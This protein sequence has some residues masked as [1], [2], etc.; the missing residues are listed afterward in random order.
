MAIVGCA[1]KRNR[2]LFIFQIDLH[3]WLR[4]ACTI[5][6]TSPLITKR[7]GRAKQKLPRGKLRA[8]A[9]V[10]MQRG[11][12]TLADSGPGLSSGSGRG[13]PLIARGFGSRA[14]SDEDEIVWLAAEID[15]KLEADDELT[16]EWTQRLENAAND[17]GF[18]NFRIWL[19]APEGFSQTALDQAKN[20]CD[21]VRSE[22]A[23]IRTRKHDSRRHGPSVQGVAARHGRRRARAGRAADHQREH[24]RV[25][26]SVAHQPF[27]LAEGVPVLP[28]RRQP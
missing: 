7:I 2:F 25:L 26:A 16:R 19:V 20:Q 22:I 9:R 11:S 18:H 24:H 1:S 4:R 5:C 28:A 8:A 12:L 13:S 23:T 6:I 14:Y 17:L 21:T 27:E 10:I 15:S 3:A